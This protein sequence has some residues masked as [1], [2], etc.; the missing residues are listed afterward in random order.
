MHGQSLCGCVPAGGISHA[1]GCPETI[2]LPSPYFPFT[3]PSLCLSLG[4]MAGLAAATC[5]AN[6][7]C[8]DGVAVSPGASPPVLQRQPARRKSI[9]LVPVGR[10]GQAYVAG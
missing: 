3:F 10:G 5:D 9:R 7:R 6:F 2:P 8:N 1:L 4:V